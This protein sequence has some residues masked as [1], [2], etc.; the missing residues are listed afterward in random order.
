M[1]YSIAR[2]IALGRR[3][4]M[5]LVPTDVHHVTSRGARPDLVEDP[6][7]IIGLNRLTHTLVHD[8]VIYITPQKLT[9]KLRMFD[10]D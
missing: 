6:D 5:G 1:R 4:P 2:L 10:D 3:D 9:R 8:G 7:N